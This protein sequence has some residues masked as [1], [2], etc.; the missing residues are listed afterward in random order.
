MCYDCFEGFY[1]D[2]SVCQPCSANCRTCVDAN[3]CR[4]CKQGYYK[5]HNYYSNFFYV[6]IK[7]CQPCSPSCLS[8]VFDDDR[9]TSCAAGMKLVGNRCFNEFTVG[10]QY[11]LNISYLTFLIDLQS[12]DF[13]S[14]LALLLNI[15]S[16][17]ITIDS[18][19]EGSTIIAGSVTTSSQANA[20]E[21]VDTLAS[22]P[23]PNYPV[24]ET[25]FT[26]LDAQNTILRDTNPP[27]DIIVEPPAPVEEK[28]NVGAIV[29][30]VIG[31]V[32]VLSMCAF[33]IYKVLKGRQ[34]ASVNALSAEQ[35]KQEDTQV[36]DDGNY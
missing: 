17:D 1:F 21:I 33:I 24:L 5:Q 23:L 32:V 13:L 36:K 19:R 26:V 25:R 10:Y 11:R 34:A 6:G 15:S 22:A 4:F 35:V 7:Q 20:N 2:G 27:Q 8:C 18:I 14:S 16:S 12:E 29:G 30:G 31:G 28:P 3:N 9:C